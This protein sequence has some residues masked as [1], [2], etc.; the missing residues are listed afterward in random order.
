MK[1][2]FLS[3]IF[4]SL[5]FSSCSFGS[6]DNPDKGFDKMYEGGSEEMEGKIDDLEKFNNILLSEMKINEN[7]ILFNGK[8]IKLPVDLSIDNQIISL[9]EKF[10]LKG[11]IV[12]TTPFRQQKYQQITEKT[13]IKLFKEEFGFN[14]S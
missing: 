12:E 13:P 11:Y 5:L 9:F 4:T 1:K 10:Q 14:E 6:Q 7:F 3:I 2:I 8:D